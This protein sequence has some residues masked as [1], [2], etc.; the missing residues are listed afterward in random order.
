MTQQENIFLPIMTALRSLRQS[1]GCSPASQIPATRENVRLF[2]GGP[3]RLTLPGVLTKLLMATAPLSCSVQFNAIISAEKYL[4]TL[5][6]KIVAFNKELIQC[7]C[8][9]RYNDKISKNGEE[10]EAT[11][12]VNFKNGIKLGNIPVSYNV[13]NNTITFG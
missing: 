10:E 1:A 7:L 11:T 5:S 2:G 8:N 12:I 4:S 13:N 6:S 3:F 9:S